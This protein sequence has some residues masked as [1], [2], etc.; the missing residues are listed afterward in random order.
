M[1]LISLDILF[2]FNKALNCAFI[3][4][5]IF[6]IILVRPWRIYSYMS[7]FEKLS[8]NLIK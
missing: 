4:A 1:V 2:L 6:L 5:G 8:V 3:E 7:I